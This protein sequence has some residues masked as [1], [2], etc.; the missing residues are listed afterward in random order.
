MAGALVFVGA[1]GARQISA[2]PRW[3]AL[4]VFCV[5]MLALLPVKLLAL[6]LFGH[7]Q[8]WLGFVLLISAKLVGT[9]VLARL[10]HLTQAS[11]MQFV[12]F[13]HWYPRWKAWKDALRQQVRE[14]KLWSTVVRAKKRVK[15]SA[16][17]WWTQV[18]GS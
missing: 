11:L 16:Q 7:G 4:L 9:A 12:W 6:Y 8:P 14:S 17:A 15:A 3:G 1:L 18:T 10:F 5:P 2:L 13:S